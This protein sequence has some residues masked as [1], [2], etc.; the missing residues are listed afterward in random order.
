[1]ALVTVRVL[2]PE[3]LPLVAVTVVLPVL[4]ALASPAVPALLLTLATAGLEEDQL[5]SC[6]RSC[7]ELSENTPVAV[8]CSVSPLAMLGLAGVTSIETSVPAVTVRLMLA[9]E[10]ENF[11]EMVTVPGDRA[12]TIPEEFTVATALLEDDQ[13]TS[14]V[15]SV[16][17][18][19]CRVA[20]A[21]CSVVPAAACAWV[22]VISSVGAQPLSSAS[23]PNSPI[24]ATMPRAR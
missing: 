11:A 2:L 16:A 5:T 12:E 6:V 10:P 22:G 4:A 7:V 13:L 19:A 17:T 3:M 24:E 15:T 8:N 1:M 14:E 9:L 23:S 21:N 20:A 18:R